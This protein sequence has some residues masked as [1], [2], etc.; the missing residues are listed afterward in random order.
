MRRWRW[1]QRGT[2]GNFETKLT[3]RAGGEV[4]RFT[5]NRVGPDG[6]GGD[7]VLHYAPQ[8]GDVAARLRRPERAADARLG[9][10]AGLHA[11]EGRQPADARAWNGRTA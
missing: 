4:G 5:V 11:P 3:D 9:Q 7:T 8:A 6:N 1:R 10:R 2:D